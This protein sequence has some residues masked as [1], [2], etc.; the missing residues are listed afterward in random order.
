MN[1]NPYQ[2]IRERELVVLR[3]VHESHASRVVEQTL[4]RGIS[5]QRHRVV[6]LQPDISLGAL[7]NYRALERP[8]PLGVQGAVELLPLCRDLARPV[9]DL[10]GDQTR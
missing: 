1:E 9:R 10:V 4:V 3:R 8:V 2:G 5:P 6:A 7:N